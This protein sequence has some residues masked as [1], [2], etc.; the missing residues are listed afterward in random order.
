[1]NAKKKKQAATESNKTSKTINKSKIGQ[2][3]GKNDVKKISV[4]LSNQYESETNSE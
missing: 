2:I 1:M 4:I 3:L